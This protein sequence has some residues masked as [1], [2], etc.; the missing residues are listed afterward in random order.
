MTEA[1]ISEVLCKIGSILTTN[2]VQSLSSYFGKDISLLIE[3]ESQIKQIQSEFNIMQA[4]LHEAQ[5]QEGYKELLEKWLQEVHV[6]AFEIEDI[7]DEYTYLVCQQQSGFWRSLK[8]RLQ[9]YKSIYSWQKLANELKKIQNRLRNL[10]GLRVTYGIELS[11]VCGTSDNF[12]EGRQLEFSSHSLLDADDLIGLRGEKEKLIEYLTTGEKSTSVISISG[13]GGSGK[14][15]LV[16]NIYESKAIKEH[17]EYRI[18]IFV[19]QN[20][21]VQDI[22]RR[23]IK[24]IF[25]HKESHVSIDTLRRNLKDKRYLLILDDVWNRNVWFDLSNILG[26]N[27][28]EGRVVITSRSRDI[29]YGCYLEMP[30]L[31]MSESW[32]L[33]CRWAFRNTKSGRCPQDLEHPARL[34]VEKCRGLPLAIVAVGRLLSFRTMDV[35]EWMKFYTQINWEIRD[36]LDNGPTSSL[37][38]ILTVSYNY[39]PS[40]LKSSFLYC[41]IFPDCLIPRKRIVRL[42][43]AEGLVAAKIT[44]TLEEVAEEYLNELINWC[45][46]QVVERNDFG[47]VRVCK[48]HDLVRALAISMSRKERFCMTYDKS[49]V[50]VVDYKARRLSVNGYNDRIQSGIDFSHLRS[51]YLFD[52]IYSSKLF[53][54]W[55]ARTA[56]YLRVLDLRD[57]PIEGLSDDVMHLFNLHYLSLR[58]TKVRVLPNSLDGLQRLQ[59]LDVYGTAIEHLPSRIT[60]LKR[61]RHLIVGK[62]L[63]KDSRN[64]HSISG[65]EAPKGVWDLQELQTLK[66]VKASEEMVRELG[67]LSQIRTIQ[68]RNVKS[69]HCNELF[70]S[71]GKMHFLCNLAVIVSDENEYLNLES[72]SPPPQHLQKLCLEGRLSEGALQSP[73]FHAIQ[74]NL[75]WLALG[76]SRLKE[77]P[78]PSLSSLSNLTMLRLQ[79]AYVG[80]SLVFRS[81]WFPKLKR[82]VLVDLPGV[83]YM[84]IEHAMQNLEQLKLVDFPDLKEIPQGIEYLASLQEIH[85]W[86]MHHDFIKNIQTTGKLKVKHIP[87][88][89]HVYQDSTGL[90]TTTN[91]SQ[92]PLKDSATTSNA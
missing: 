68:V 80:E 32:N 67:K 89:K 55:L 21:Q 45:L 22:I 16:R 65:V 84:S 58:N 77:D 10:Q 75:K 35:T 36:M 14:S 69:I 61:L 53:I 27:S 40:H 6:L 70:T 51:F 48:M 24:D 81:G 63:D 60:E 4:F 90:W 18:W 29:T 59:T 43:V 34:I 20:G 78:L 28:N 23:I 12:S 50:T 8:R 56:R 7:I 57:V 73:L 41:S 42:L 82:L 54:P 86:D 76:W 91:L 83:H 17:F 3:V 37:I 47:R 87:M 49:Q 62:V 92:T 79:K 33:F 19:S 46:L 71:I 25:G 74:A 13:I 44:E 11:N 5:R 26:K 30:Y 85:L 38:G 1:L 88:I 72:P 2:V 15:T 52:S 31:Q 66:A 9:G 64:F 39:L